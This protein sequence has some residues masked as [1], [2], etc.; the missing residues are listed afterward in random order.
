[1]G[2]LLKYLLKEQHISKDL[3]INPTYTP[4]NKTLLTPLKIKKNKKAELF[5][6]VITT[7]NNIPNHTLLH[8]KH[9]SLHHTACVYPQI[10]HVHRKTHS[11][12]SDENQM[13]SDC[14]WIM[15]YHVG[16]KM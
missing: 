6:E 3:S 13:C 2:Y 9:S 7:L 1:M 8:C 15:V 12:S 4:Q 10:Q 14:H 16:H 5:S 11:G